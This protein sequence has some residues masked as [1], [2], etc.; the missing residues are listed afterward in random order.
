MSKIAFIFPGQGAQYVGMGKD[1]YDSLESSRRIFALASK[2]SGFDVPG[3]CF[4]EKDDI[5]ITKYTQIAMLTVEVV[6]AKALEERG[7]IPE[8]TAGL[9]LGEYAALVT[10]RVMSIEDAC[11][12][13]CKRGL[14]MQE[15]VPSGG[16][17]AAVLGLSGDIISRICEETEGIV[18]IANYNCP[19]QI[20]IT[21]EEHAVAKACEALKK[22]KAKRTLPL[23]VSGP[24]HSKMLREASQKL[25][26][27]LKTITIHNPEIPYVSNV[28][29]K[30]VTKK[31]EIKQ[32]CK[33]Q[34]CSPVCWQQSMERMIE[35]GI[36]TFIEIGP[37]KTLTGFARKINPSVR[38]YQ[39]GTLEELEKTVKAIKGESGC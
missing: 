36:D 31:D 5:H 35:D 33:E 28:T 19:G 39:V 7:I 6:M 18:S 11:K 24:F 12:V 2:V 3:I 14:F 15:A 29:A 16:A 21:G 13:V 8:I 9:S 22:A 20:V 23:R 4:N 38:I 1:F 26:Q 30:A 32:L 37:G 34:I 17:M 25:E 10:A 27:E